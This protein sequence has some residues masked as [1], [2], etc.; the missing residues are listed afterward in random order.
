MTAPERGLYLRALRNGLLASAG[1][2]ALVASL[3]SARDWFIN[4]TGIFHGP[5]G[6]D[7]AIVA[8]TWWS[9]FLPTSGG[10]AVLLLPLMLWLARRR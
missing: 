3:A 1:V 8:E 5:A 7:W 10:V 4:P 6:T 2:A 9:W